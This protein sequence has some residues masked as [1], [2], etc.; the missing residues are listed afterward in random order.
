MCEGGMPEGWEKLDVHKN[1][2]D[3]YMKKDIIHTMK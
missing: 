2:K 1:G 3:I